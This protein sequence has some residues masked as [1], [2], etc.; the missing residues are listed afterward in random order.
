[1][2]IKGA[3]S[4]ETVEDFSPGGHEMVQAGVLQG[5]S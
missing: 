2:D 4:S 3:R 5:M 1:M